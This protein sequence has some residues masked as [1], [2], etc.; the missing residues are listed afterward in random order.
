MAPLSVRV[1][2]YV[3]SVITVDR[4]QSAIKSAHCYAAKQIDFPTLHN[5][6][7]FSIVGASR[8]KNKI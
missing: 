2:L 8:M 7:E 3:C 4:G 6:G 5:P 1:G